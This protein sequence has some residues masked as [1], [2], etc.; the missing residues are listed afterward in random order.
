MKLWMIEEDQEI[1]VNCAL[2]IKIYI[3][4]CLTSR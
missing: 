3:S 4:R 1:K 2:A